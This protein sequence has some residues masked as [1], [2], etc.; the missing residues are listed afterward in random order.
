MAVRQRSP[1]TPSPFEQRGLRLGTEGH[2]GLTLPALTSG[3][4]LGEVKLSP[5][6]NTHT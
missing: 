4:G 1:V 2:A 3:C 5:R 6:M